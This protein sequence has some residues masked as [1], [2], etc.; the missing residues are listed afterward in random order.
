[1]SGPPLSDIDFKNIMAWVWTTLKQITVHWLFQ[2]LVAVVQ[3]ETSNG[4]GTVND[5]RDEIMRLWNM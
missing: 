5:G 4:D 1:M 3:C 2:L